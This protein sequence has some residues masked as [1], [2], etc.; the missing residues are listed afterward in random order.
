MAIKSFCQGGGCHEIP[1]FRSI[2][3]CGIGAVTGSAGLTAP[4]GISA[5]LNAF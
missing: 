3:F 2:L 1:D 5:V 4:D